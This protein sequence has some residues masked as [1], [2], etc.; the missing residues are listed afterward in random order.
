MAQASR[1]LGMHV[2]AAQLFDKV[3][4]EHKKTREDKGD[5]RGRAFL[6]ILIYTYNCSRWRLTLVII[7]R[8]TCVACCGSASVNTRRLT[9]T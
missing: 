1:D 5:K 6:L 9:T 7:T 4:R 8:F 3:K 2:K